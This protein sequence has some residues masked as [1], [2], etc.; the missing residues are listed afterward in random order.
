MDAQQNQNN[1]VKS[2]S[3]K[4]LLIM[5]GVA[6]GLLLC[7]VVILIVV[8]STVFSKSM[9]S[10]TNDVKPSH[11][12]IFVK[13][14]GSLL[15]LTE[16]QIFSLPIEREID[17]SQVLTTS[18]PTILVWRDNTNL[19][20]FKFYKLG[21]YLQQQT[22]VKYNATPKENGVV[23]IVPVSPLDDGAYCLV[24]GDPL[25]AFL[26]G[27]CFR[28]GTGISDLQPTEPPVAL[29]PT[30]SS[31]PQIPTQDVAIRPNVIRIWKVGSPYQGDTPEN[32]IPVDIR[33]MAEQ[34]GYQLEMETFPA[35]G[36]AQIF[37]DAFLQNQ[38][39]DILS[40]NNYGILEGA[41]TDFGTFQGIQTPDVNEKMVFVSKSFDLLLGPE[42][43]WVV[44]FTSSPNHQQAKS[45]VFLNVK[46]DGES[47]GALSTNQAVQQIVKD[48][49]IAYHGKDNAALNELSG[50]QYSK[51]S[52][53]PD[54]EAG[55]ATVRDVIL[56]NSWGNEKIAFVDTLTTFDGR[57]R[58]GQE[59]LLMVMKGENQSW[60]LVLLSENVDVIGSL[61]N[62]NVLLSATGSGE[63][64]QAPTLLAPPNNSDG[65]LINK[66]DLRWA[67]TG[68]S[69][70][71]YIVES[72]YGWWQSG[73]TQ[74]SGSWL[75]YVS[76][77]ISDGKTITLKAPFGSGTQPHRWRVWAIDESGNFFI[78]EWRIINMSR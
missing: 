6:G 61:Y 23:E 54:W 66:P 65:S 7:C 15:E 8:F 1:E 47:Q 41:T 52:S 31:Q 28:I 71:A 43:G 24:Q 75:V 22:D 27:W 12:G 60:Q 20:Y 19:D 35:Q 74:W 14:N 4:N 49:S 78:S 62:D 33:M 57:Y 16:R 34:Q 44:M 5:L 32:V 53:S 18:Q 67:D 17:N 30:E 13:E 68:K 69:T 72:Q 50:G 3:N 59:H 11:Y 63:L 64:V 29:S 9:R 77:E 39:P 73:N 10:F 48:V 38:A 2:K 56:C 26:S 51:D 21:Q 37:F 40:F 25:A 36:F 58:I 70:V 55:T 76:P 46:C 42:G 45:L